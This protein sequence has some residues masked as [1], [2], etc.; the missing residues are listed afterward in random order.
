M[1]LKDMEVF[2][3]SHK[4]VLTI[5]E[6][7]MGFPEE[8]KF[9]L[10]TQMR[11]AAVSIPSN[12]IEGDARHSEKEYIYFLKI[13]IGSCSE[14]NYQLLLSR[15]LNFMDEDTYSDLGILC[16]RVLGMLIRTKNK[17]TELSNEK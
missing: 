5:Y 12:L 8:E 16:G 4:L 11:R 1:K 2:K 9:G 10:I 3:E 6:I 13:A 17:I 7:T 15:E 14:L